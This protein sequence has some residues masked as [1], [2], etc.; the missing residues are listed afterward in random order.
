VDHNT[1]WWL[2]PL[3]WASA[4]YTQVFWILGTLPQL[5][6]QLLLFLALNDFIWA[7][8]WT[9]GLD[10]LADL[11]PVVGDWVNT[12]VPTLFVL[13]ILL[14]VGGVIRRRQNSNQNP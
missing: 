11:V 4:G 14:T 7:I 2:I 8:G 13:Y 5:G 3:R 12:L 10:C 9:Y 6:V 1:W